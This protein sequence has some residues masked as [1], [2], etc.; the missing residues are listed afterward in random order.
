MSKL[1]YIIP[2]LLLCSLVFSMQSCKQRTEK[3]KATAQIL[4][5]QQERKQA[6]HLLG[7]MLNDRDFERALPYIDSLHREFPND[8][9]LYFA[10]GWVYY[11]QDDSLRARASFIKSMNIYDSL[12]AVNSVF[13]DMVN[14]A[15]I[16]QILY[17]MEAYNQALNKIQSIISNPKDSMEIEQIWRGAVIN[18]KEIDFL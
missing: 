4:K 17:G 11:M 13:G 15:F 8:P 3:E 6:T 9:Q 18:M 14:R 2:F 16:V 10:Q 1:L 7:A 5:I 12:I